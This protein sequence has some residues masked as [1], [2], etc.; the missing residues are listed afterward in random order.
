MA[1]GDLLLNGATPSR[2]HARFAD[3]ARLSISTLGPLLE[4]EGLRGK[5]GY[6][7]ISVKNPKFSNA[8][9]ETY[10]AFSAEFLARSY[11]TVVDTPYFANIAANEYDV[12]TTASEIDKLKDISRET[13]TRIGRIVA[14]YSAA[15]IT[16]LSWREIERE[17]P[18]WLVE[19]IHAAFR[20]KG[21]FYRDI[22]DRT[23]A[24]MPGNIPE[25]RLEAFSQFLIQELPVL[26]YIYFL[27]DP[28]LA[29]FYPDEN[30]DLIWKIERG[31]YGA[32]LPQLTALAA[33]GPRV[34]YVDFRLSGDMAGR[35]ADE[36]R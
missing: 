4:L 30:P 22:I 32:E 11:L 23:R 6:L 36:K 9:I 12:E 28:G 7:M 26:F 20:S 24:V 27:R 17:T 1:D 14:K 33:R 18:T 16:L 13:V 25:S 35:R 10:C 19:E 15:P 29:D 21:C 8:L 34:I 31:F 3:L 5:T 2:T